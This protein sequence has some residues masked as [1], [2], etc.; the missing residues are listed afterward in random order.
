MANKLTRLELYLKILEAIEKQKALKLENIKEET[1]IDYPILEKAMSFLEKQALVKKEN[2]K[3]EPIY[4]NTP[5]GYRVR[6]FLFQKQEPK[7]DFPCL[8]LKI[9]LV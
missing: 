1:A 6:K 9:G 7:E 4:T 8:N 2:M 5:R 3:N